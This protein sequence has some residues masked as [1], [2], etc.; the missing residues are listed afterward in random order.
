MQMMIISATRVVL[1]TKMNGKDNKHTNSTDSDKGAKCQLHFVPAEAS[2]ASSG[3]HV[4]SQIEQVCSLLRR[5]MQE[6]GHDFKGTRVAARTGL[7]KS[8]IL[9]TKCSQ[10][11]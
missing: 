6:M 3:R 10:A 9:A 11:V 8:I 2:L 5:L 4:P 7:D 1:V